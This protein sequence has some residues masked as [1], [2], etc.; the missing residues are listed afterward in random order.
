MIH[1]HSI[2]SGTTANVRKSS[3]LMLAI[4]AMAASLGPKYHVVVDLDPLHR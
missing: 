3:I 2:K 1:G 4:G